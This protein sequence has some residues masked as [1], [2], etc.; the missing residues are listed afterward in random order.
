MR[1]GTYMGVGDNENW[2][3]SRALCRIIVASDNFLVNVCHI[4]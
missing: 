2:V 4:N 3:L 1:G